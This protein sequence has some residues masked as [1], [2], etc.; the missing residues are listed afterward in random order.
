MSNPRGFAAILAP[1]EGVN[2]DTVRVVEWHVAEAGRVEAGQA[3]ATLETT[4]STFEL[5]APRA[6]FLFPLA[7]AGAE[8]SVGAPLALVADEPRRP[9]D[10]PE[11]AGPA[12]GPPAGEQ[13][14]TKKAL[15]LIE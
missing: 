9:D 5:E 4:K 11:A 6:G 14:V 15:A 7:A 3:V 2:D 13:V 12:P 1:R 8:V 10:R